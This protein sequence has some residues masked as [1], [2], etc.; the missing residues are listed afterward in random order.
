MKKIKKLADELMPE[1]YNLSPDSGQIEISA[2]KVG[3]PNKRMTL[4][5]KNLKITAAQIIYRN[6][7]KQVEH[8]VVRI[9]H[10]PTLNQVRLHTAQLQYPG[11]YVLKL[12]FT[13][14][15]DNLDAL[16]E[17]DLTNISLREYFPSIDEPEAKKETSL[18]IS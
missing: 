13:G 3:R 15:P 18:K 1:N 16:R 9:N 11:E 2:R 17:A 14:G 4:H 10:L 12:T 7:N 8:Q 6:K 5:Q